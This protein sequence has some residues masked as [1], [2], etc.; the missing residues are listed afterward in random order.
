[1]NT[2]GPVIYRHYQHVCTGSSWS[3][4]IWMDNLVIP[5]QVVHPNFLDQ[6]LHTYSLYDKPIFIRMQEIF[7]MF[8]TA[9]SSQ[10][11][12]AAILSHCPM[13]KITA[14]IMQIRLTHENK[15]LQSSLFPVYRKN[16]QVIA[17]KNWFTVLHALL[18][19]PL[20]IREDKQ[21]DR[22]QDVT[23]RE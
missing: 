17:N 8:V 21:T 3:E 6:E 9:S 16:S 22:W 13:I 10:I 14:Q 4:I 19:N 2:N 5:A 1:M 18:L 7:A 12:L 11:F 20:I 23:F 15:S